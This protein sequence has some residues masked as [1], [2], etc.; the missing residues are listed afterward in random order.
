[1]CDNII[2]SSGREMDLL[3]YLLAVTLFYFC[4]RNEQAKPTTG[5]EYTFG[6][7][8]KGANMVWRGITYVD[9]VVSIIE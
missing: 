6:R 1:M 9:W 3:E 4:P 5:L 8:S 7:R 2:N